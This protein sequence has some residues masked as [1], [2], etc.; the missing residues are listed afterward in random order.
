[1][2][3]QLAS[4]LQHCTKALK[5]VQGRYEM[6]ERKTPDSRHLPR[7]LQTAQKWKSWV[8]ALEA[9]ID[10]TESPDP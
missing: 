2:G 7:L 6:R 4:L 8:E 5:A 9:A 10:A 3:G 1:M